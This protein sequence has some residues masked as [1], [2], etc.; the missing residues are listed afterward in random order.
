MA[1]SVQNITWSTSGSINK[2]N[3][4]Y[5]IDSGNVWTS[6]A[7]NISNSGSY[8]WTVP[9]TP[10]TNCLVR[11]SDAADGNPTDSS[12]AT[13]TISAVD[14][15]LTVTSPNGGEQWQRGITQLITWA[16][17]GVAN[18]KIEL[19]KG[20]KRNA[21][22][23]SSF[24]ASGGSFSW[25]IPAT[26]T[27]GSDYTIRVTSTSDSSIVDSSDASFTI[28]AP[29]ITVTAPTAGAA[30]Q[31]GI[32]HTI[33]WTWEGTMDAS[34]KIL[35]Y[36]GTKLNS[37]L[38]TDTPND[39]SF[40]WTIPANQVLATTYK[41]R[42]A[43]VD[44]L[45]TA[46]SGTFSITDS[47]GLILT[48][49][50]NGE[51]LPVRTIFPVRWTVDPT[52]SA[53]KLEYSRDNGGTF[54]L[55]GDGIPNAGYY[56][57]DVPVNFTT[58]GIVRVSDSYGRNWYDENGVLET[59]FSF[60]CKRLEMSEHPEIIVWHGRSNLKSPGYEFAKV[61]IGLNSIRMGEISQAIDPLS[62]GWHE[63][64]I[65]LD[66]KRDQGALFIDSK[67]VLENVALYTTMI[68]HFE[69]YLTIRSGGGTGTE[70]I[71]AGLRVQMTLI[72][73]DGNETDHFT[74]MNEDFSVY[75]DR[76]N[77]ISSCWQ[78]MG[79]KPS[80]P[81]LGLK[82]VLGWGRVLWLRNVAG[83]SLTISKPLSIPENI[84]FDISDRSFSIEMREMND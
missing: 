39:G 47:A 77:T 82:N 12:N 11:V 37:T 65:R 63:V 60:D 4:D 56:E 8:S 9:T 30:W 66:L 23:T 58:N 2:I 34:V 62:S 13:F 25:A 26:Q 48:S 33:T 53:V 59:I 32:T 68:H 19:M 72:S 70:L 57:W 83:S 43:T 52:V 6:V 3:I 29:I 71:L 79:L 81:A 22:L 27:V 40:D 16:S 74:I 7:T 54:F 31:R 50:N 78:V 80:E 10:S 21:T 1:G 73:D 14:A 24:P 28:F 69:P 38:S 76:S 36:K 67:S 51:T 75:N 45:V 17:A 44:G 42:I 18:I 35:L 61:E 64:K 55:I 49:P 84:P 46:D 15:C 41:I 20:T 5:S